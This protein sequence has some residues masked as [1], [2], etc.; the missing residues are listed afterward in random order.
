AITFKILKEHAPAW[1]NSSQTALLKQLHLFPSQATPYIIELLGELLPQ[2]SKE[3]S[4]LAMLALKDIANTPAEYS[5]YL[6]IHPLSDKIMKNYITFINTTN[7]KNRKLL[8]SLLSPI[9][10]AA[11]STLCE[12]PEIEITSPLLSE[13]PSAEY[14]NSL[15]LHS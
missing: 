1:E 14:V 9:D 13:E 5:T 11:N 12:I 2:L 8:I 3:N 10:L 15:L 4:K 7:L 6:S